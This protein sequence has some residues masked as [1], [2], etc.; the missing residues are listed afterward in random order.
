MLAA[1]LDGIEKRMTPPAP[2]EEDLYHVDGARSGM[3]TLPGDLGEALDALRADEV[4][5]QALG[6][7]VSE[8]YLEAKTLEWD[9]YRLHVSEWDLERY[10]TIY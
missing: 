3:E 4:I 9:E 7:H 2:A 8:R 6:Q 10:L 5:Q 1:G